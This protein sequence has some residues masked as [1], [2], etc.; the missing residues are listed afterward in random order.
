MRDEVLHASFG[1]RV[2]NQSVNEENIKLE[3]KVIQQMWG[4]DDAAEMQYAKFLLPDPILGSSAEDHIAQFR[5]S[6]TAALTNCITK[7][8]SRE[9]KTR[10]RGWMSKL[11]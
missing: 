9:R 1:I 7:Y 3:P 5:L 6:P 8:H 11:T 10:Y 2:C 4:E